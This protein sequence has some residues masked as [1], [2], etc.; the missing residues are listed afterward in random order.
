MISPE[1][2]AGPIFIL[3][4]I[5]GFYCFFCSNKC[6]DRTYSRAQTQIFNDRPHGWNVVPEV[7]PHNVIEMITIRSEVPKTTV[8]PLDDQPPAYESLF[9][10]E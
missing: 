4:V 1:I 8:N 3:L 6:D 2:F 10:S 9:P 7:N 5:L